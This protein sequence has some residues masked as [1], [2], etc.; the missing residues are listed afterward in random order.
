M[1]VVLVALVMLVVQ[2][3]LVALVMLVVQ[4]MLVAPQVG[5]EIRN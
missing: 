3:M 2:V 1:Q 4:V 5:K